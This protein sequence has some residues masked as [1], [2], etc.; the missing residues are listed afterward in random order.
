MKKKV[1]ITLIITG[2]VIL[3]SAITYALTNPSAEQKHK[4]SDYK[5]GIK[6]SEALQS[7]KPMLALMYVDWCGYCLRFMPKY[8]CSVERFS[9][10]IYY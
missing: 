4:P 9:D 10:L 8:K 5:I 3:T 7:D 1:L 2:I 6:Y